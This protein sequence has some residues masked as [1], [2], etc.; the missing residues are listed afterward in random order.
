LVFSLV[1]VVAL[2]VILALQLSPR[3][4]STELSIRNP[5]PNGAKAAAEILGRH[6]VTVEQSESFEETL[7]SVP[8]PRR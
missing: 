3:A 2:A 8:P 7:A 5:A 1:M 4:D 6:G